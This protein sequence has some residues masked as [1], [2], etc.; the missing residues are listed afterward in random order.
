MKKMELAQKVL[1]R[2]DSTDFICY[3]SAYEGG[4][5]GGGWDGKEDFSLSKE[6]LL[7]LI[8]EQ[9]NNRS[10]FNGTRVKKIDI[11]ASL[12]EL[13]TA[14]AFPDDEPEGYWKISGECF[15]ALNFVSGYAYILR[16]ILDGIITE[17][18][19]DWYLEYFDEPENYES[20]F[21]TIEDWIESRCEE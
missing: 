11:Q 7:Y 2:I 1:N 4:A 3:L 16:N 9:V 10:L 14:C 15:P 21:D 18:D 12:I 8:K 17:E 19:V 5:C 20:E 6:E 13:A